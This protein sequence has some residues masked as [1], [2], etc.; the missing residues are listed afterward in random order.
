MSQPYFGLVVGVEGIRPDYWAIYEEC[1]KAGI[2]P[3]DIGCDTDWLGYPIVYG[4][5]YCTR[6]APGGSNLTI[7][8]LVMRSG[9][10]EDYV[11]SMFPRALE[12]A[13]SNVSSMLN[14]CESL[15]HWILED[16]SVFYVE[17]ID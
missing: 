15:E 1:K 9:S 7:S 14:N 2:I 5:E 10:L 16:F 6:S 4:G 11:L 3:P 17:D 13:K 12:I 8:E